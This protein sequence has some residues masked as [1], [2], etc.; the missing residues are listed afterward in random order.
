MRIRRAWA[1]VPAKAFLRGKSRL[2]PVLP[3]APRAELSRA[4]LGHVLAVLRRCPLEGVL[5]LADGPEVAAWA[6]RRG[7]LA[8]LD[9]GPR[10][11][12]ALVDSGLSAAASRGALAA[13]VLMGDL[14]RLRRR[15]VLELLD[16]VEGHDVVVAPDRHEA[17][18]GA[19]ALT[20]PA[21][22]QSCFGHED[23]FRRHL[24]AAEQAGL[25]AAVYRSPGVAFD[26]DSPEDHR[27]ILAWRTGST[28]TSRAGSRSSSI[29]RT[30]RG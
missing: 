1:V 3:A 24:C 2:A 5:V 28:V 4:L 29:S 26:V 8:Q 6:T 10:P 19:L 11:L 22:I 15:D 23:S 21:A 18:T 7:A 16:L 9:P 17:G 14:P 13:V 20:L 25:R 30:Q 12:G 27:I